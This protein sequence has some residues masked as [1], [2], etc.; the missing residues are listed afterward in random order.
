M[1]AATV[2]YVHCSGKMFTIYS[3]QTISRQS[4]QHLVINFVCVEHTHKREKMRFLF[5]WVA[6]QRLKQ[7]QGYFQSNNIFYIRSVFTL[8]MTSYFNHNT[9]SIPYHLGIICP[10]ELE[11]ILDNQNLIFLCSIELLWFEPATQ[12]GFPIN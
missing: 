9:S 2:K 3:R 6:P 8:K 1:N 12:R 7:K 4:L 10:A 11:S 5:P